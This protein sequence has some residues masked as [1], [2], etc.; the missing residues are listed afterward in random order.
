MTRTWRATALAVALGGGVAVSGGLVS[1]CRVS[2][3]DVH[4]WEITERGP[5]K[6]VA[7]P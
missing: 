2:E 5:F 1:G 7:V 4:R 3:I 6:L